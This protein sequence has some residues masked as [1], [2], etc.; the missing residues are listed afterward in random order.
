MRSIELSDHA[1]KRLNEI[2][3]Y[4][5]IRESV[6]RT[7]KILKS[8]DISFQ[9]IAANPLANKKFISAKF[10]NLDIRVYSHYK[11]YHIYFI[12]YPDKI[13]IAEIFHLKQA[14]DKLIL[15]I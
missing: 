14:R 4:Y 15:D 5:I 13:V 6:E 1:N 8:F 3:D 11:T 9:K 7:L 10:F 2:I 12:V